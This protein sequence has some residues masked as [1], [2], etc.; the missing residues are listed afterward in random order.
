MLM[1]QK[2]VFLGDSSVG[3]TCIIGRFMTGDFNTGYEAT[4]GTDF[5]TKTM[6]VENKSIQ[7]QIWDTAGQERYRS[8]IPSYIR[9]SAAA[10]IVYDI[11]D[12]TTFENVDKWID[13]VHSKEKGDVC[14]FLVGNKLDIGHREVEQSEALAKANN[15]HCQC[16]ET[17]AKTNINVTELFDAITEKLL[18]LEPTEEKVEQVSLKMNDTAKESDGCC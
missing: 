3:K 14:L 9:D 5:S 10:V 15:Y 16:F 7:L 6:T 11:N 12:R 18:S 4:I 17:S 1:K 8:L 13:D 2:V